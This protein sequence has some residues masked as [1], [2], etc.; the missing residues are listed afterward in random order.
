M[1][2]KPEL[3]I[4]PCS[5][6]AA[7]FAV[8]HWHY[9]GTMPSTQFRLGVWEGG[10]FI[11]AVLFG[12]GA[13]N[14]THGGPYGLKAKGEV[15][16]LVRVALRNHDAPVS[17]ILSVCIKIVARENPK[18]RMLISFAD[19]KAQNHTGTIYQAG[20]WRYLGIFG[21][22]DGFV[23]HGKVVHNRTIG[24]RGWKQQLS[25]LQKHIDTNARKNSTI[26]VRYGYPLDCEIARRLDKMA[27]PYPTEA[28]LRKLAQEAS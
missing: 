5:Y 1:S 10:Q 16:E 9:S 15:A 4:A 23:I 21:G 17:R 12:I 13:G 6:E 28:E 8:E 20:N 3:H 7:K 22:H 2:S 24:A 11:G 18:L 25:W 14:S 27:K 26:K 19:Y